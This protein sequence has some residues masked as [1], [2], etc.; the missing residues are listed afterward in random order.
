VG[1]GYPIP[2]PRAYISDFPVTRGVRRPVEAALA[3]GAAALLVGTAAI[4]GISPLASE[5]GAT[6]NVTDGGVVRHENPERVEAAATD[7]DGASRRL[8]RSLGLRLNASAAALGDEEFDAA[9][10]R[11]G[12][13]Y[14]ADAAR[15]AAL[16]EATEDADDDEIAAAFRAAGERQRAAVDDAERFREL[17]TDYQQARA[18]GNDTRARELAGQLTTQAEEL[19]RTAAALRESYGA[20]EPVNE[21]RADRAQRQINQSI[22][23]VE[24]L[25]GNARESTYTETRLT[26]RAVDA[27]GSP[28]DPLAVTGRLTTANGTALANRTVVVGPGADPAT[29]ETNATGG[30]TASYRPTAL[31]RGPRS[32]PVAFRPAGTGGYLG[33]EA[34]VDVTVAA[35]PATL[36]LDRVPA[37]ANASAPGVVA[38][39]VTV[40]GA[41]A[42]GVPV[43]VRLGDRELATARTDAEGRFEARVAP[44]LAVPA[45]RTP[46]TVVAGSATGP[47]ARDSAE[48]SLRI[49][50]VEPRLTLSA[51]RADERTLDVGGRLRTA[52]D[53]V[54]GRSVLVRADGE[55]LG[56]LVTDDEG[57][58]AGEL[59][60]PSAPASR[61]SGATVTVTARFAPDATHLAAAGGETTVRFDSGAARAV[62][63]LPRTPLVALGAAAVLLAG[64]A[65]AVRRTRSDE[66]DEPT[67]TADE[68]PTAT[69]PPSDD[70]PPTAETLARATGLAG[71]APR[72][73]AALGYAAVRARLAAEGGV[74]DGRALT[75][76]EFYR[77]CEDGLDDETRDR[78][79]RLTE[80]YERATYT[81]RPLDA[82]GVRA[83][84]AAF[85]DG[86]ARISDP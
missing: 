51:S 83:A 38:G 64:A 60:L 12:D 57:R 14:R 24:R 2:A 82:E 58:F 3:V 35:V 77:A 17:Y 52:A 72:R 25:A 9:A 21:S 22:A 48:R 36:T 39:R 55:P 47:V 68:A 53:P 18:A 86:A 85:E 65:L 44:P 19:N 15:L 66:D 28:T 70:G 7:L 62:D 74:A 78:F 45:G 4:G 5:P 84:L 13:D 50:P 23:R 80:L 43:A 41:A 1:R 69:E 34:A 67:A 61:W 40:D 42:A 73:A 11:L 56:L 46:L 30:F 16:A 8:A 71:D 20:L 63:A 27:T 59:A 81:D 33:S 29:V 26:A 31:D 49:T 6:A 54:A 32:L 10:A 79:R 37:T 75:H 76:W